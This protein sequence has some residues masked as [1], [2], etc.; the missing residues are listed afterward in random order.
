MNLK[1]LERYLRVNLLGLGPRLI[2]KEFTVPRS[3][4]GSETLAYSVQ[5]LCYCQIT[6]LLSKPKVGSFSTQLHMFYCKG[7]CNPITGLDRPWWFQEDEAPRFQNN[8][9]MKMI[10]LSAL[11]TGR[12]YSPGNIPGTHFC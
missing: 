12:L 1:K 9:Y 8:R 4:R 2:K 10:S 3:H 5:T 11:R 7:K 6:R